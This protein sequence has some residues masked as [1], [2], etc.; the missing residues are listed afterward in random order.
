MFKL[1]T[2]A[3]TLTVGAFEK[4]VEVSLGLVDKAVAALGS[5]VVDDVH[6]INNFVE[7]AAVLT[8][9]TRSRLV[10]LAANGSSNSRSRGISP[11]PL[12]AATS[13]P[14]PIAPPNTRSM[15]HTSTPNVTA[16]QWN[17][18]FRAAGNSDPFALPQVNSFA[19]GP[20]NALDGIS[21]QSYDLDTSNHSVFPPPSFGTVS[22]PTDLH[23]DNDYNQYAMTDNNGDYSD[24]LAIPLDNLSTVP[25]GMNVNQNSYGPDVG[26]VDLLDVLLDPTWGSASFQ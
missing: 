15:A 18:A 22:N 16:M 9:R 8:Q 21:T 24:W 12:P 7:L 14:R 3:Q 17:D 13:D 10:R 2:L 25:A 6:I 19:S 11:V 5:S 1:L 23:R 26:G 20:S 4:D